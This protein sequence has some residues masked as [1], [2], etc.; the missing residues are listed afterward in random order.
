MILN[1]SIFKRDCARFDEAIVESR[2]FEAGLTIEDVFSVSRSTGFDRLPVIGANGDAVGL[3]ECVDILLDRDHPRSIAAISGDGHVQESERPRAP[4]AI[5][6]ARL[7]LARSVDQ[8]R[9]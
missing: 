9:I 4:S 1:G 5:A 8:K 7:G 2:S 6:A 3:V